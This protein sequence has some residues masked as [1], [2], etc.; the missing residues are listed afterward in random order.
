MSIN[1]STSMGFENREFLKNTAK[2]I[3]QKSG[4]TPEKASEI[5]QKAVY[6]SSDFASSTELN[7]MKASV[8]ITLNKSLNETLKYLQ[9]HANDKRKKY[10]LGEL[11]EHIDRNEEDN[12]QGE[13]IDFKLDYNLKNIF[14]A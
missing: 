9:R 6:A 11:W 7:T 10:I 2:E 8:Q 13:L 3:L 4:T 12:Y 1:V 5:A 14:A